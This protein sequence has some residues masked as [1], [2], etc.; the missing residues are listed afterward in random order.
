MRS[1]EIHFE[2]IA[3]PEQNP[4]RIELRQFAGF[5][6]RSSASPTCRLQDEAWLLPCYSLFPFVPFHTPVC[7]RYVLLSH[8]VTLLVPCQ[9]QFKEL[10]HDKKNRSVAA[11]GIDAAAGGLFHISTDQ[12]K[13]LSCSEC[14]TGIPRCVGCDGSQYRLAQQAGTFNR[15]AEARSSRYSRYR[16]RASHECRCVPGAAACRCDVRQQARA[17]VL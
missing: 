13:N 9:S 6:G 8:R 17:L 7:A 16:C 11:C 2:A 3:H 5:V 10:F 12:G 1:L 14:G 4:E 15:R